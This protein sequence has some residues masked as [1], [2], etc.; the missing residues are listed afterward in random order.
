M[1]LRKVPAALA[2][3]L[4][5]S[6]L[7]HTGLYGGEHAM[8]G[9]YHALLLQVAVAGGLGLLVFFGLL[10][11]SG[12]NAALNGSVLAA[13][14]TERLPA[15]GPL[16]VA[17][18]AWYGVAECLEPHHAAAS[19]L[20]MPLS[21]AVASWLVALLGRGVVAVLAGVV[22][23]AWRAAFAPRT[24]A[25]FRRLQSPRPTRRILWTRS[26]FA[27]PPPIGLDYCA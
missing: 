8:G 4:L 11:A 20:A 10:A 21:L 17:A 7:A 1:T 2:L 12:A 25:W 24:P 18:G 26:R 19:L 16:L 9:G 14:L 15:Y 13:R 6:I 22:I 3:G 27:R 23:A 5:A